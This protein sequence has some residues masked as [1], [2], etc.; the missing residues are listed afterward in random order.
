MCILNA[1]KADRCIYARRHRS[2]KALR[3]FRRMFCKSLQGLPG[4]TAMPG[5]GSFHCQVTIVRMVAY[6]HTWQIQ[7]AQQHID[8]QHDPSLFP[9]NPPFPDMNTWR[10][11]QPLPQ[12]ILT[13]DYHTANARKAGA[14][15]GGNQSLNHSLEVSSGIYILF[16]SQTYCLFKDGSF[17][18]KPSILSS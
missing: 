12:S 1:F 4:V 7:P 8:T 5:H 3:T 13:T 11:R 17:S 9:G 16:P 2:G 10:H 18:N 14:F 6:D 15:P